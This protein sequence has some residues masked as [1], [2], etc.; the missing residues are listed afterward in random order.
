MV[1][2][3]FVC[4]VV[5]SVCIEERTCRGRL[6]RVMKCHKG[7]EMPT[8][9]MKCH[10]SDEM[11]TRCRS[12]GRNFDARLRVG[13]NYQVRAVVTAKRFSRV[14]GGG[15]RV[16]RARSAQWEFELVRHLQFELAIC[17]SCTFRVFGGKLWS[18]Q[19]D[20]L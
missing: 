16:I 6:G 4:K 17:T 15:V 2:E 1:S 8:R 18:W 20:T 14:N 12:H 7:D 5:W 19:S 9:V 3:A 13:N 11:L 10:K